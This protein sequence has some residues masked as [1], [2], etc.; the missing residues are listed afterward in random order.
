MPIGFSHRM[1]FPA[2]AALTAHSAWN[3]CGVAMYTASTSLSANCTYDGIVRR[4]AHQLLRHLA[5]ATNGEYEYLEKATHLDRTLL[6]MFTNSV[7]SNSLPLNNN[8][9]N[10]DSAVD[11]LTLVAFRNARATKT[12]LKTPSGEPLDS[13]SSRSNIT[14]RQ[15]NGYDVIT[16]H[17]PDTGIWKVT[18]GIDPDNLVVIHSNLSAEVSGLANNIS[19]DG[20]KLVN[21][22][23][24]RNGR[25]I[26]DQAFLDTLTV[27]VSLLVDG[28]TTRQWTLYDNGKQGDEQAGDGIFGLNVGE[29][30]AVGSNQISITVDGVYFQRMQRKRFM[31][32]TLP[33]IAT[34]LPD[35]NGNTGEY[36]LLVIPFR[37]LIDPASLTVTAKITTP[38]GEQNIEI[39]RSSSTAWRQHFQVE[40][41]AGK[42]EIILT[43]NGKTPGSEMTT[44]HLDPL[45]FEGQRIIVSEATGAS[46]QEE[47]DESAGSDSTMEQQAAQDSAM[48]G[49][50]DVE[51]LEVS[52]AGWFTVAW[53]VLLVNLLV[54]GAGYGGYW[55]WKRHSVTAQS[56]SLDID[57]TKTAEM[58]SSAETARNDDQSRDSD[59]GEKLPLAEGEQQAIEKDRKKDSD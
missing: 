13:L 24:T 53:Q 32:R 34:L 46:K 54:I 45:A 4:A 12:V 55:T 57:E 1:C 14:W 37:D 27:N 51:K 38:D 15:E 23:L 59:A 56:G 22:R 29:S 35:R 7:A 58:K 8:Q 5:A 26:R 43:V 31:M 6:H 42:H 9:I 50:F 36:N 28:E 11:E 17:E 2:S 30:P 47:V 18:A 10:V 16:I 48:L 20:E 21:V 44:L 33:V 25:P 49:W 41:T 40:R 39:P 52:D 3:G 19:V